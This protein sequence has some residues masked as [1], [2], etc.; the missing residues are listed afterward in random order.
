MLRSGNE[1]SFLFGPSTNFIARA[2]AGC[3]SLVVVYPLDIAHT[4]LAADIGKT[5][6]C[7]G[8]YFGA[9]DTMK[10]RMFNGPEV[11]LWK[12]YAGAH[13]VSTSSGLILYPLDTVKRRMM[14]QSGLEKPMYNSTFDCWRK[15]YKTEGVAS[16]YRGAGSSV[17]RSTGNAAIL[18]FYN[19]VKRFINWGGL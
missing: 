9:F 3:T 19:E 1:D 5:E 15:I 4:R 7:Q 13:A 10:E 11:P 12:C 16:F 17:F 6:V 18:V 14:M 8:I 2:L